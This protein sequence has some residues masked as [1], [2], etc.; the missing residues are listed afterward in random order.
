MPIFRFTC[1]PLYVR[2]LL[3]PAHVTVGI[4]D[5]VEPLHAF[6]LAGQS[7][8]ELRVYASG[9]ASAYCV[10]SV[11]LWLSLIPR[12]AP[13]IYCNSSNVPCASYLGFRVGIPG[14]GFWP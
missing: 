7:S 6:W 12:V 3:F 14:S 4:Y 13:T 1:T 10:E 2:W 8:T 9:A 5:G 11:A